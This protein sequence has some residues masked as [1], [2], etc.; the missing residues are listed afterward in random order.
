MYF[1]WHGY[2]WCGVLSYLFS[3]LRSTSI[4]CDN[5]Y[6]PSFYGKTLRRTKVVHIYWRSFWLR[7]YNV[8][9]LLSRNFL[10][11]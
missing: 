3:K 4:G 8:K 5:S 10:T 11:L 6:Q 7:A 9:V 1:F 2:Y